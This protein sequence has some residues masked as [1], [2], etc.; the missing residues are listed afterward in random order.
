M[1]NYTQTSICA[2][3]PKSGS[4][5]FITDLIPAQFFRHGLSLTF[6]SD[7]SADSVILPSVGTGTITATDNGVTY[8]N[9]P[10]GIVDVK[11]TNAGMPNC[12]GRIL[13]FKLE[14]KDIPAEAKYFRMIVN[15]YA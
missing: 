6:Y 12:C 7:T 13:R 4:G 9:I 2:E 1:S 15:S 14:L 3:V 10:N 11:D 5:E 8:G